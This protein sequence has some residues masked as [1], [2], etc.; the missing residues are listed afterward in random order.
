[1]TPDDLVT[2]VQTIFDGYT[3][4]YFPGSDGDGD[5]FMFQAD[6]AD[7]N[8]K[9]RQAQVDTAIASH[10]PEI[11]GEIEGMMAGQVAYTIYVAENG[12]IDTLA[13]KQ[14]FVSWAVAQGTSFD[15][16]MSFLLLHEKY[17]G[18]FDAYIRSLQ[19]EL[20]E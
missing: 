15:H 18:T 11:V 3:V 10:A 8:A 2:S 13:K 14:A 19:P 9:F 6:G 7:T 20:V 12:D 5:Y 17:D 4:G 16:T 1:M